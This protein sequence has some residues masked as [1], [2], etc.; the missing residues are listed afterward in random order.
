M[1]EK[2]SKLVRLNSNPNPKMALAAP[3]QRVM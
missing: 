2:V 3:K 1:V